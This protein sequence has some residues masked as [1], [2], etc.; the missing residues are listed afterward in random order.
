MK[1]VKRLLFLLLLFCITL[2]SKAKS[3]KSYQEGDILINAGFSFL[4]WTSRYNSQLGFQ[5]T[6]FYAPLLLSGEYGV[7]EYVSVGGYMSYFSIKYDY[8]INNTK[9]Y[10]RHNYLGIGVKG[11]FHFTPLLKSELGIDVNEQVLDLYASLYAG[12]LLGRSSSNIPG[13]NQI[14]TANSSGALGLAFGARYYFTEQFGVFGEFG[15]GA[16]GILMIGG[17]IK[18]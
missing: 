11:T 3:G 10:A 4:D 1:T 17:S 15:P 14:Y 6:G 12:Y 13:G 8:N 18:F 7:H 9:Y 16:L 5:R 2:T